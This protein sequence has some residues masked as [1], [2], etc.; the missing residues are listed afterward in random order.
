MANRAYLIGGDNSAPIGPTSDS[1]DPDTQILCAASY[2]LPAF[3]LFCFDQPDLYEF[4]IEG[5]RI[6]TALTSTKAAR[7]RLTE[8]SVLAAVLFAAHAKQWAE[9]VRFIRD[10]PFAYITLDGYEVWAMGPD[11]FTQHLALLKCS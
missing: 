5:D 10:C 4:E 7:E 3:W 9:W 1:Y 2:R 6:P 8:R 11:E